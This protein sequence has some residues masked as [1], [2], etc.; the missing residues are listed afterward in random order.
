MSHDLPLNT[1][2]YLWTTLDP[3]YAFTNV[4]SELTRMIQINPNLEALYI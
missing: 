4:I 2:F 1:A 3:D